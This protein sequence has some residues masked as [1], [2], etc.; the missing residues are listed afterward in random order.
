MQP[1]RLKFSSTAIQTFFI[2]KTIDL[3]NK[4][5]ID[6]HRL[7]L[8]NPKSILRE[9]IVN[10][11]NFIDQKAKNDDYF[12]ASFKETIEVLKGE[13]H[14]I[15]FQSLTQSYFEKD[16]K[17]QKYSEV[18]IRTMVSASRLILN[19]NQDYID[20]LFEEIQEIINRNHTHKSIINVPEK[21]I[22]RLNILIGYF[23]IEL[24]TLGY[25]KF[26][27]ERFTKAV[28]LNPEI[29][30][31]DKL[32]ILINLK[33]KAAEKFEV[34]FGL[35]SP[36]SKL[37]GVEILD[38]KFTKIDKKTRARLGL[39]SNEDITR[40]LDKHKENLLLKL[41]IESRDFY[42]AFQ[43]ARIQALK[44]LDIL[45]LSHSSK[46]IA[47]IRQAAVIG[48]NAP[49]KSKLYSNK[50]R[51]EGFYK[52]DAAIYEVL[53]KK[54]N[55]I[56]KN[57]NISSETK[58]KIEAGVRYLRLGT[59]A[60]DLNNKLLNYWI[61][62]EFIFSKYTA[63][64]GAIKRLRRYFKYC[65]G[66]IYFK[67][68]IQQFH[69]DID[70][71]GMKGDI[72]DYDDNLDYLLREST[73]DIITKLN[74]SQLLN[75]RAKRYKKLLNNDKELKAILLRHIKN[76]EWNL[77]RIYSIR[78]EIVHS[79]AVK[80]DIATIVSH[81]RYYLTFILNALIDFLIE[82]AIDTN[83]DG[84]L[85]IDDYLILCEIKFESMKE[86]GGDMSFENMIK[87]HNPTE[88]FY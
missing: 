48:E 18:D 19:D 53:F 32:L 4:N 29:D 65:H 82:N 22:E 87:I 43:N 79:A 11:V 7:R 81:L 55:S 34:V 84:E 58:S 83:N 31:K 26:Y 14:L 30:F 86:K 17:K 60:D 59:E 41:E 1:I 85:S 49:E 70:K 67:R 15:E 23:Y 64:S 74:G 80:Y 61:G 75:Y 68:N 54:L 50:F 2:E 56:D 20:R 72:P 39:K 42:A 8:H 37:N 47:L 45:H 5:T 36:K 24:L 71:M 16:D 51:I 33:S 52:S 57:I 78:N 76:I 69:T 3:L 9:L 13:N 46:H 66:L 44:L 6:T 10:G 40:F 12:I 77:T 88:I 25:S 21:D 28:L 63:D 35:Y 38:K 27:L 73:Y 62:L